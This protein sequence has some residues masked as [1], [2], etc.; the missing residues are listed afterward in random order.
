MLTGASANRRSWCGFNELEYT[1][2]R[3]V[4]HCDFGDAGLPFDDLT[5]ASGDPKWSQ[6][7]R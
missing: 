6:R 3:T 5:C 2:P 4:V 1:K 7:G